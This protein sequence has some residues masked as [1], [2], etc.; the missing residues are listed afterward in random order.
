MWVFKSIESKRD[1]RG[2]AKLLREMPQAA[3]FHLQ[4]KAS[5]DP[6]F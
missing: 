2:G 1:G 5:E 3:G 4:F 6:L